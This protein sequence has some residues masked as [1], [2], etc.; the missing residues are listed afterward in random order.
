MKSPSPPC[1][2]NFC[3]SKGTIP[4]RL[5]KS[6][7]SA[8]KIQA[9]AEMSA[10]FASASGDASVSRFCLAPAFSSRC[11]A[12][13]CT[14]MYPHGKGQSARTERPPLLT[15]KLVAKHR[16]PA[17]ECGRPT[18]RHARAVAA[19]VRTRLRPL[20]L[21]ISGVADVGRLPPQ[22]EGVGGAVRFSVGVSGLESGSF[23][24]RRGQCHRRDR[25]I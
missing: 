18:Q 6:K 10:P 25:W 17:Q 12:G 2:R 7:L 13:Y 22:G 16:L 20:S 23:C 14:L 11:T 21:F 9:P 8:C 4:F 1:S 19:F 3:P 5:V 24:S 15:R